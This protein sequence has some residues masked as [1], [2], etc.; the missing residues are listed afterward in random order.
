MIVLSR[1]EFNMMLH[2]QFLKEV[3][4]KEL[5][6]QNLEGLMD[7]QSEV[8]RLLRNR[9]NSPRVVAGL[10]KLWERTAYIVN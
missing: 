8:L 1:V 7:L 10:V 4:E 2:I 9:Y 6:L 5:E 3:L